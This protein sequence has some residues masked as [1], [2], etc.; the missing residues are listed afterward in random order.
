MHSS[1]PERGYN[2]LVPLIQ[3]LTEANANFEKIPDGAMGPLRFNVDVLNG[4]DQ[5][6]SL[7]DHA[8]AQV[9]I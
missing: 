7:P 6:N 8:E 3:L 4:G 1:T 2:A 9:N 5:V